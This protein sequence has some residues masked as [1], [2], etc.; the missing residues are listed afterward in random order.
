[1]NIYEYV[2]SIDPFNRLQYIGFIIIIVILTRR[3]HPDPYTI[4]GIIASILFV[5]YWNEGI[6]LKGGNYLHIMENRLELPIFKKTKNM[7]IDPELIDFITNHLE[8]LEY[9]PVT[10]KNIIK[11]IDNFLQIVSDMERGVDRMG[12][13]YDIAHGLKK[14]I[15]NEF[16]S[17]IHTIPPA[18]ITNSK[19]QLG[20]RQIEKLL[21]HHMDTIYSYMVQAY[22]NQPININTKFIYNNE[23]PGIDLQYNPHYNVYN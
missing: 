10:Y 4:I 5:Y 15:M 13:N 1:M 9:N 21:N 16:Q 23:L 19:F 7:Y 17:M 20:L 6:S 18:D 2:S 8:Y 14:K 22:K 11:D 3:I 12:D